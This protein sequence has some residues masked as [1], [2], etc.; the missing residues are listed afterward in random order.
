MLAQATSIASETGQPIDRAVV[1]VET[2]AALASR[3]TDLLAGR[4]DAILDAW[5]VRAPQAVAAAVEWTTPAGT[6][7]GVT[8]GIEADGALRVRTDSGVERILG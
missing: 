5:R 8:D 4:F 3:Y 1:L 2:L 6:M 7:S